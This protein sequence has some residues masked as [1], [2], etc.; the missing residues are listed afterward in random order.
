MLR[1]CG[2]VFESQPTLTNTDPRQH[3]L[4]YSHVHAQMTMEAKEMMIP[5]TEA[6]I[7]PGSEFAG[8]FCF[9]FFS[10]CIFF[11]AHQ[12]SHTYTHV[13][14]HIRTHK[15]THTYAHICSE[16]RRRFGHGC[17]FSS[18][19]FCVFPCRRCVCTAARIC[20][21]LCQLSARICLFLCQLCIIF[22]CN[23]LDFPSKTKVHQCIHKHEHL[24][25][26]GHTH[27]WA[28]K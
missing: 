14:T 6:A 20:L 23:T 15:H 9:T 24:P 4:C 12:R 5:L 22:H 26:N 3:S 19:G 10:G 25:G 1:N 13:H 28:D 7:D 18:S 11:C 16:W 8:D 27:L 2:G 21:F 17:P